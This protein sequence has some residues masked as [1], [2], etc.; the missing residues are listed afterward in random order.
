[1][2]VSIGTDQCCFIASTCGEIV[3]W[4]SICEIA[5]GIPTSVAIG[6]RISHVFHTPLMDERTFFLQSIFA[7]VECSVSDARF[8]RVLLRLTRHSLCGQAVLVA[9]CSFGV[10]VSVNSVALNTLREQAR[11]WERAIGSCVNAVCITECNGRDNQIVY[12]NPAFER[13]TGYSPHECLGRDPRFMRAG[14]LDSEER[15]KIAIAIESRASVTCVIRNRK[16]SGE[17]FYNDLRIDPVHDDAGEV[18][19]FIAVIN[20]VTESRTYEK[21]LQHMATHD[22]LTN[23]AN[24]AM[25][26]DRLDVAIGRARR[27]G[28]CVALSYVDLDDFKAIN[29]TLGHQAGD[30]V[31]RTVAERLI[32]SVRE[33]DTVARVGGDEFVI[34]V[35]DCL[36]HD[37]I[38]E[39]VDRMHRS[40][41]LPVQLSGCNV[42]P[43]FSIGVGLFPDDAT[44]CQALLC[45]ADAAMYSAKAAGKNRY[46]FY[47]D[48]G[49]EHN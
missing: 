37:H 35:N 2:S 46:H 38:S 11:L 13:V 16:R 18:T 30:H 36:G 49:S 43:T 33:G 40:L 22:S 47:K 27:S 12:V 6:K 8:T 7:P 15:R 23:L 5:T 44:N 48:L 25:L 19:H 9:H 39:F 10:E 17:I 14:E 42:F 1:M 34:V 45:A 4:N 29:D 41:R 26:H 24:R 28:T 20:D 31:L 21:R 32:H 3:D